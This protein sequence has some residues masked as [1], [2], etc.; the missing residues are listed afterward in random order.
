MT[1][2]RRKKGTSL[3]G[4]RIRIG[5]QSRVEAALEGLPNNA[6]IGRELG[7]GKAATSLILR[8]GLK[9]AHLRLVVEA[10]ERML[11]GWELDAIVDVVVYVIEHDLGY[12]VVTGR[13]SL[14]EVLDMMETPVMESKAS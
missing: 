13:V 14:A 1:A 2:K 9:A 8:E 12:G 11:G 6:T 4:A 7:V 10:V 5:D 3:C